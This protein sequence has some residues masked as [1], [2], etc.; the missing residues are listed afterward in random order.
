[1]RS[2]TYAALREARRERESEEGG[3]QGLA[4]AP[5]RWERRA[6]GFSLVEVIMCFSPLGSLCIVG[7]GALYPS[8]KIPRAVAKGGG[9][10]ATA[11]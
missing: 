7:R 4:H 3:G 6:R 9:A 5:R 10:R 1:V 2:T 8:P 11:A